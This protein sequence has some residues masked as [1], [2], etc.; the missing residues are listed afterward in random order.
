MVPHFGKTEQVSFTFFSYHLSISI[1]GIVDATRQQNYVYI[2][3]KLQGSKSGNYTVNYVI[4][5][6]QFFLNDYVLISKIVLLI[7]ISR[8]GYVTLY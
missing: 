1:F 7:I 5:Y 6:V 8:G 3:D 2:A 4:Q